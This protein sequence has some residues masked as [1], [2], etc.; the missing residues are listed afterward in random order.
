MNLDQLVNQFLGQNNQLGY[1]MQKAMEYRDAAAR[2][3]IDA[4]EYQDLMLDLAR[5]D[6]IQ[7]SAD[8]LDQQIAF[9]DCINLL[10]KVPLP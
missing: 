6:N 4:T 5:L 1:R 8:E 2:G 3:D 7:L 10:L 9:N